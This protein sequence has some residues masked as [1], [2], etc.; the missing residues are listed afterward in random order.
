[1]RRHGFTLIEVMIALVIL[2][3]VV[4][5]T[6]QLT[7][8]MVHTVTTSGQQD[9]AVELAQGRLAQIQAD[10]NYVGLELRYTG[11]ETAFPT[12]PGF[13]RQTQVIHFGGVGLP[14]DYKRVTVSVMGPGLR[15]PVS[16]TGTVAAP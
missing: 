14:N 8:G 2:A 4:L 11:S 6:A 12:L 16:R 13:R 1:M 9:A 3:I 10:P 15:G 5:G 7:A